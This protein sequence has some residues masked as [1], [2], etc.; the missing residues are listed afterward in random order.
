MN[1]KAA[2]YGV[3]VEWHSDWPFYP[4]TNDMGVTSGVY[5]DDV[6]INNEPLMVLHGSHKMGIIDHHSYEYFCRAIDPIKTPLN[7][8]EAVPLPGP[9]GTITLHHVRTVHGSALNR[10]KKPRRLLLQGYFA[11]D[12]WPLNGFRSGQSI[13][14]FDDLIL[15]GSATL[16]PGLKINL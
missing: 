7:F 4:H 11:T 1:M 16:E 6:D 5:L 2:G 3:A 8:D 12:A 14:N 15:R 9:A 13:N 10:F